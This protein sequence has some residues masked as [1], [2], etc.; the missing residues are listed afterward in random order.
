M[1]SNKTKVPMPSSNQ[2][3]NNSEAIETTSATVEPLHQ[4][5][6]NSNGNPNYETNYLPAN[7]TDVSPVSIED[8]Q[9]E[10][11]VNNQKDQIPCPP[12]DTP[13]PKVSKSAKVARPKRSA[14]Q[15]SPVSE[16]SNSQV[17]AQS[18]NRTKNKTKNAS[19]N[20]LKSSAQITSSSTKRRDC[21]SV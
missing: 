3:R 10:S 18:T 17:D 13:S 12:T 21:K 4:V 11:Q 14:N 6:I 9:S 16:R 20:N 1:S 7:T 19:A 15:V 5:D 8:K 2:N